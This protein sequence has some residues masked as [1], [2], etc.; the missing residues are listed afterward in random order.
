MAQVHAILFDSQK[1]DSSTVGKGLLP[2]RSPAALATVEMD[3]RWL[4]RRFLGV[5]E[6]GETR[7]DEIGIK[8][9]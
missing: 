3:R 4:L 1:I 6:E 8:S 7:R 9:C 2:V 5:T